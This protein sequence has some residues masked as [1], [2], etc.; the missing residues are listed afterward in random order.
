[1]TNDL[2]PEVPKMEECITCRRRI[3]RGPYCR[4]CL[5]AIKATTRDGER[6]GRYATM[7]RW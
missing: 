7:A 3:R 1:M 2:E 6:M 4:D 5:D